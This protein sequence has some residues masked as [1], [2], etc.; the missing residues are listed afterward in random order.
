MVGRHE[1]SS[2][3]KSPIR[4]L[5]CQSIAYQSQIIVYASQVQY[6]LGLDQNQLNEI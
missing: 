2:D 6:K 4:L 5:Q 1:M 3:K